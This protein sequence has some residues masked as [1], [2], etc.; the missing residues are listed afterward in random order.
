MAVVAGILIV[1]LLAGAG[2]A[3]LIAIAAVTEVLPSIDDERERERAP[4]SATGSRVS[5]ES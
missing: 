3:V 5:H 2:V 1:A 4:G